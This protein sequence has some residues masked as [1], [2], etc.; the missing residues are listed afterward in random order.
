MLF[1]K[2]LGGGKFQYAAYVNEVSDAELEKYKEDVDK[3]TT[4]SLITEQLVD[5]TT[6]AEAITLGGALKL[7][8]GYV[9]L[10]MPRSKENIALNGEAWWLD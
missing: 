6:V 9:Y 3:K 7:R 4:T 10:P 2:Q 1:H 5:K 8:Y